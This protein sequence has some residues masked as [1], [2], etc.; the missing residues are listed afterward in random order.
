MGG[1]V[2]LLRISQMGGRSR[3]K[4]DSSWIFYVGYKGS[5]G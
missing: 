3:M 1:A 2:L 4:S 5:L